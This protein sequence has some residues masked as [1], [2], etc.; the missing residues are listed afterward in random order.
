MAE[1][2]ETYWHMIKTGLGTTPSQPFWAIGAMLG[3]ASIEDWNAW[4]D[5]AEKLYEQANAALK[6]LGDIETA[7]GKGFPKWNAAIAQQNTMWASREAMGSFWTKSPS[8]GVPLAIDV[9]KQAV[10]LLEIVDEGLASYGH[11][12]TPGTKKDPEKKGFF[13]QLMAD[14]LPYV[15]VG[16]AGYLLYRGLKSGDG[17]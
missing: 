1:C 10:C 4:H 9:C 7:K 3:V 14:A 8:E 17:E 5:L 2:G 15:F 13:A 12:T 16:G 6:R 11:K